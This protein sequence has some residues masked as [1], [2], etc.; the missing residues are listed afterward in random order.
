MQDSLFI[1]DLARCTGCQT[2]VIACRDRGRTPADQG[3]LRVERAERG[4]F[5]TLSLVYRVIHCFHCREP[6][7]AAV[8]PVQAIARHRDGRVLV[9][10]ERCTGCGDCVQACPFAAIAA[11]PEEG[12]AHKCDGC[13]DEVQNGWAPTCVRACP[14]RA[15]H[16]RADPPRVGERIPD[17]SFDDR[18]IG[19]AVLYLC[20]PPD[21]PREQDP[22][23]K[24]T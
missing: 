12:I 1:I 19:P 21:A 8:C 18:G 24:A 23:Q 20:R 10:T 4:Q 14:M 3:W 22:R 13:G 15:L 11:D 7:C 17:P 6:A 9:D 16:F 2:C 5:P